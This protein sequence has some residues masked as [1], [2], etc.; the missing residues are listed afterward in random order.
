A[1]IEA[2]TSG[3]FRR[4]GALL[5]PADAFDHEPVVLTYVRHYVERLVRLE[6]S[7]GPYRIGSVELRTS[8]VHVH[9]VQTYGLHFAHENLRV[10]YVPC[11]RYFDGL[12]EDYARLRPDVLI[13]NV[14]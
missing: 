13:V 3:G 4:R 10:A 5:A 14:L 2:M 6:P 11:G 8:V 1:L 9:A 7:A 12:A